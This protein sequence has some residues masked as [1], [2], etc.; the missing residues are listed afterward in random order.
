[1]GILEDISMLDPYESL[2]FTRR[3]VPRA[4][5]LR[6]LPELAMLD[7]FAD[8]GAIQALCQEMDLHNAIVRRGM[9][10][11]LLKTFDASKLLFSSASDFVIQ[12]QS[13]KLAAALSA[14]CDF[15]ERIAPK[16]IAN[17]HATDL[18][19]QICPSLLV[20]RDRWHGL[21]LCMLHIGG[22][23]HRAL[24]SSPHE[25]PDRR[26]L[27][28]S[29]ARIRTA[30]GAPMHAAL[31]CAPHALLSQLAPLLAAPVEGRLPA[32]VSAAGGRRRRRRA[33]ASAC[34]PQAGCA[35]GEARKRRRER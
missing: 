13:A 22:A 25:W 10:M 31:R 20:A 3:R 7:K 27:E 9:R 18:P 28:L 35:D 5:V 4:D 33:A 2:S 12:M 15:G 30:F 19:I 17:Q 6:L 32:L 34:V 8:F 16:A 26:A 23:L 21:C 11:G 29:C 1:M 14:L 24:R